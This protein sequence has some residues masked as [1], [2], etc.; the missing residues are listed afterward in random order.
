MAAAFVHLQV[1]K[2]A[3]KQAFADNRHNLYRKED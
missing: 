1:S 3:L 2:E